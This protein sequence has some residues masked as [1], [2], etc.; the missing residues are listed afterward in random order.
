VFAGLARGFGGS[1]LFALPLLMTMEM[2]WLGSYLEPTRIL[3]LMTVLFPI[4]IGVAHCLGFGE[5]AN[6]GHAA[7]QAITAY[8]V[9]IVSSGVM[10]GIFGTFKPGMGCTRSSARPR[11]RR[12]LAH[13]AR[14]ALLAESHFG[15]SADQSERRARAAY[16]EHLFFMVVGALFVALTVAATDEMPLIGE[17]MRNVH[18]LAAVAFSL[19]LL[20]FFMRGVGFEGHAAAQDGGGVSTFFRPAVVGYSLALVVSAFLLYV[21]G[22]FDDTQIAPAIHE[23]VVLGLPATIGAAAAR[24]ILDA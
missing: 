21:F 11:F 22:R 16:I 6:V 7:L 5:T 18:A 20:H 12:V 9:A 23:T 3:L 10:L 2:W 1:I 8:G 13:S 4:L 14:C 24:L 19:G 17:M 15:Q